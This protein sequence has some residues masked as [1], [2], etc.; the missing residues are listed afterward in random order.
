MIGRPRQPAI[1]TA[2]LIAL[3]LVRRLA[4]HL[5]PLMRLLAIQIKE[6][7]VGGAAHITVVA[8]EAIGRHV[9]Q[10]ASHFVLRLALRTVPPLAHRL[11][12]FAIHLKAAVQLMVADHIMVAT[13]AIVL[14]DKRIK[15][16]YKERVSTHL[17][18]L[19]LSCVRLILKLPTSDSSCCNHGHSDCVQATILSQ[20]LTDAD[21]HAKVFVIMRLSAGNK[22]FREQRPDLAFI[23]V[24]KKGDVLF[25]ENLKDY[26]V[27]VEC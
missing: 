20:S 19:T 25:S 26:C 14:P 11:Q 3:L 1:Q 2:C 27:N 16:L 5:V 21:V 10:A 22:W 18:V 7:M 4:L 17:R 9:I 8:T 13:E 15:V 23:A 12:Q 6:V 24:G